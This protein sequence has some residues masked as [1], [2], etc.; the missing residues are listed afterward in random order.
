MKI[1]MGDRVGKGQLKK[2]DVRLD[3]HSHAKKGKLFFVDPV[4]L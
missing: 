1:Y 4:S 2:T 3:K